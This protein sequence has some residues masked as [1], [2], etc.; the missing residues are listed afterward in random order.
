MNMAFLLSLAPLVL[1]LE[2]LLEL[3][4]L[5]SCFTICA[6]RTDLWHLLY[7]VPF[8]LSY[9]FRLLQVLGTNLLA[10]GTLLPVRVCCTGSKMLERLRLIVLYLSRKLHS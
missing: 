4:L 2:C 1:E 9:K 7:N 10:F 5:C 8:M 6:L 3:V